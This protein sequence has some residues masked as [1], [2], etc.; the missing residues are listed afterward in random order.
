MLPTVNVGDCVIHPQV[1]TFGGHKWQRR[2]DV[3]A[4]QPADRFGR[5]DMLLNVKISCID[6]ET[7]QARV[8]DALKCMWLS[9]I[10]QAL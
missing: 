5:P 6:M 8:T 7:G 4:V 2:Y 9:Q 10:A 1:F 3:L